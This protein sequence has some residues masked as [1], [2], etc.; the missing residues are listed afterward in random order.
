VKGAETLGRGVENL[1]RGVK[2][3]L[4]ALSSKI[5]GDKPAATAAVEQT[6]ALNTPLVVVPQATA[7]AA[8]SA[9]TP[10]STDGA[11]DLQQGSNGNEPQADAPAGW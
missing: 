1:G 7:P 5:I 10:G 6:P 3:G 4:E 9:P 8:V 11:L 2:R